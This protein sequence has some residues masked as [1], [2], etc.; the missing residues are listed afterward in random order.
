M[1]QS[2]LH[3]VLFVLGIFQYNKE[4]VPQDLKFSKVTPLYKKGSKTESGNYRPVSVLG[5]ISKVLERVIY[6][7]I[8]KYIQNNNMLYELQSGFR[9]SY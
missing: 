1:L 8:Y 5:I 7:Q 3:P 4:R 6:N 9:K 2:K